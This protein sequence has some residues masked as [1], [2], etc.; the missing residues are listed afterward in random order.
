MSK[1]TKSIKIQ[2]QQY[3]AV[4]FF[5][6]IGAVCGFLIAEYAIT[7]VMAEKTTG[8]ALISGIFLLVGMYLSMFLQIVLHEAGH[9]LF[10]LLSGYQFA[11]F[12][13]GRFTWIKIDGKLRFK[14]YSLAGTGGQCLM[15]PPELVDGKMPV[16]LYNLGGSLNNI[17]VSLICIGLYFLPGVKAPFSVFLLM[18]AVIG[19]AFALMNGIPMRMGGVDNDG[20]NAFSLGK[21]RDALRAFWIQLKIQEQVTQG[22]RLKDMPEEW[23]ELPSEEGMQN[24]LIAALAVFSCNR[25]MDGHHFA[26]AQAQMQRL[27]SEKNAIVGL[28]RNLLICDCLFC[29]LLG[30]N[31]SEKVEK[32]MDKQQKKFMKSM[33]NFLSVL[34][35]EYAYALLAGKDEVKAKKIRKKFEACARTYPYSADIEGER[36]LIEIAKEKDREHEKEICG[37]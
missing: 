7:E 31:R 34:R 26:E 20:Y 16:M 15:C 35:T 22:V 17:I 13:I 27:L 36:E 21:N 37:K 2:W 5:M 9:L 12:R 10:G 14:K 19:V 32:W 23:F 4:I 24:S 8:E 11:S 1:N 18:T 33:K 29:E 25:L 6:M 28:Y 30:E 3:L